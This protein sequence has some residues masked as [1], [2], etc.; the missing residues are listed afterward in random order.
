MFYRNL[1]PKIELKEN[2]KFFQLLKMTKRSC[3]LK[4]L[5]HHPPPLQFD[6]FPKE[7]LD[8]F[9]IDSILKTMLDETRNGMIGAEKEEAEQV[10]K[11]DCKKSSENKTSPNYFTILD[12][13]K[14]L[15]RLSSFQNPDG[16]FS[17]KTI[18][19]KELSK[20][21]GKS[22]EEIENRF[23]IQLK[24]LRNKD[25]LKIERFSKKSQNGLLGFTNGKLTQILKIAEEKG[26]KGKGM[27][28]LKEMARG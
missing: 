24:N 9:K 8:F 13:L 4:N 21:L 25:L 5:P 20:T 2:D 15:K 12:D 26:G 17:F 27:G 22:P 28:Y 3:H 1:T 10:S 14:I 19:L 6:V 11:E 18:N 7:N 16:S 23:C